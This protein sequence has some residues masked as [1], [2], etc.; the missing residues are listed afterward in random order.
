RVDGDQRLCRRVAG[1]HPLRSAEVRDA[2]VGGDARAGQHRHPLCRGQPGG[3]LGLGRGRHTHVSDRTVALDGRPG[4][5]AGS[6][7]AVALTCGA[8]PHPTGPDP[9]TTRQGTAAAR[10]MSPTMDPAA[11]LTALDAAES[12]VGT[13]HPFREARPTRWWSPSPSPTTTHRPASA[14]SAIRTCST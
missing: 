4:G 2:R 10:R 1:P 11:V 13:V 8:P 7:E 12:V 3:D 9:P 6:P 5:T 14:S